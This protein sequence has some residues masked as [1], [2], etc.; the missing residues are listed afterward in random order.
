MKLTQNVIAAFLFLIE[1]GIRLNKERIDRDVLK[2]LINH[3][4]HHFNLKCSQFIN[5]YST[6]KFRTMS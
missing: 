2:M 5:I 1:M 4:Q 6:R 3:I